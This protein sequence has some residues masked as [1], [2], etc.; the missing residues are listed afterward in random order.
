MDNK[1]IYK[2]ASMQHN[3]V[4]L[5]FPKTSNQTDGFQ[6]QISAMIE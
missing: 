2:S 3:Q 4:I 1:K 5:T 6:G